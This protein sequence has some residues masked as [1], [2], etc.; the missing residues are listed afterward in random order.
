MRVYG[1]TEVKQGHYGR[2]LRHNGVLSVATNDVEVARWCHS[3]F[4]EWAKTQGKATTVELIAG[5]AYECSLNDPQIPVERCFWAVINYM[6][7]KGWEPFGRAMT[8]EGDNSPLDL[9]V[10]S[11]RKVQSE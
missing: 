5:Q 8:T 2:A 7:Q 1:F 6:C 4:A 10:Y 9:H 3:T 11:L